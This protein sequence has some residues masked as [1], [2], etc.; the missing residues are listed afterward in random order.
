[1][2]VIFLLPFTIYSIRWAAHSVVSV[3]FF[4]AA[5]ITPAVADVMKRLEF[6]IRKPAGSQRRDKRNINS[7]STF[8]CPQE[9]QC[10]SHSVYG[11]FTPLCKRSHMTCFY[12]SRA[13]MWHT[14][15]TRESGKGLRTKRGK[16]HSLYKVQMAF[17]GEAVMSWSTGHTLILPV[18]T[19]WIKQL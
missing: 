13:G 1:M 11:N 5:V 9:R 19:A 7:W 6:M 8:L 4:L 18:S 17:T 2:G 16:T 3:L 12:Q 15:T 14:Q 10:V